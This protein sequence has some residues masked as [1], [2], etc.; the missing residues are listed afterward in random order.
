MAVKTRVLKINLNRTCIEVQIIISKKAKNIYFKVRPESGLSVTV[1]KGFDLKRLDEI[2]AAKEDWI[3]Q[4]LA[5]LATQKQ[6]ERQYVTGEI[7]P[8]LG[9]EY[10]LAVKEF[11]QN[12]ISVEL[13]ASEFAASVPAALQGEKRRELLAKAVEKWYIQTARAYIPQRVANLN[14]KL[15][16]DYN[17][18]T[19]RNQRT[20][21]GSCSG[22]KNLNFNWRLLLAPQKILDYIIM[23]ELAHLKE[24]NHSQRF[25][26]LV[27]EIYPDYTA[28]EKW[29]KVNGSS[30]KL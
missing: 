24:M 23:H 13:K 11:E 18:V 30:L 8:F 19:I 12:H 22:Q 7:L 1:P 10:P 2:I 17:R 5:K 15:Q 14:Q 21:W 27:E 20:R 25:W 28:A 9:R 3:L 16:F 4:S 26:E 6:A 29:L